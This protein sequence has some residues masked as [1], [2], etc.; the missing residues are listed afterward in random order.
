MN[1]H[2]ERMEEIYARAAGIDMRA[3]HEARDYT[4][5]E[6][7]EIEGLFAEFENEEALYH[8]GQARARLDAALAR[9]E[10]SPHR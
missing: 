7:G 8:R 10:A 3:R 1:P 5:A 4:E 2:L 9:A 6:R